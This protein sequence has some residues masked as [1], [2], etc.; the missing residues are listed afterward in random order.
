M[1]TTILLLCAVLASLAFGVLL[2]YWLC[3]GMFRVFR[4]HAEQVQ[5][6]R[7]VV[8]PVRVAQG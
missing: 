1:S 2:A 5:A 6:K 8:T 4:I 7:N 3:M